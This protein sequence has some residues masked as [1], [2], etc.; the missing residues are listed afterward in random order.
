MTRTSARCIVIL[1]AAVATA[2]PSAEA[3][4]QNVIPKEAAAALKAPFR[5]DIEEMKTQFVQLAGPFPEDKLTWRPMEGV[6]SVAEV[7]A[8]VA[9]ELNGFVLQA[10]GGKAGVPRDQ[11]LTLRNSTNKVEL[12]AAL[13]KALDHAQAEMTAADPANAHG[14][15]APQ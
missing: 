13:N 9:L 2:A 5:S 12:D 15:G 10:F 8:L 3:R 7:L 6:R 4:A 14:P 11:M 1:F